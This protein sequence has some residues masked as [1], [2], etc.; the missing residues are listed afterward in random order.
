LLRFLNKPNC[1]PRWATRRNELFGESAF[2]GPSLRKIENI[3][4]DEG[5]G[6]RRFGGRFNAKGVAALYTSLSPDTAIREANQV[7]T[8][9]PTTLV[10][11]KVDLSPVFD[12]RESVLL[13]EYSINYDTLASDSRR[14]EML[15]IGQSKTQ[16]FAARLLK[17]GFSGLIVPSYVKGAKIRDV[18]LVIWLRDD[19]STLRVIDDEENHACQLRPDR[20]TI[21]L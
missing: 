4:R 5:E 20:D 14:D 9:Q 3:V 11:Y 16:N 7:G 1:P 21:V 13:R 12:A 15:N 8:L 2:A 10:A 6:A 17:E 18:N 19:K